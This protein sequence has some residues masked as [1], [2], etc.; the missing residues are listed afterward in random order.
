[1]R[2][3]EDRRSSAGPTERRWIP[4]FLGMTKRERSFALLG[5]IRFIASPQATGVGVAPP[6]R[7]YDAGP[8]TRSPIVQAALRHHGR[9]AAPVA[10]FIRVGALERIR[11][12]DAIAQHKRM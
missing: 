12:L 11:R 9:D 1:V 7:R 2:R 6:R 4:A 3:A 8:V 10:R 5:R